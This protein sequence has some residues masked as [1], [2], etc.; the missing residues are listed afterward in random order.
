MPMDLKIKFISKLEY[1]LEIVKN[2]IKNKDI[3]SWHSDVRKNT[4][5][6]RYVTF[7]NE[8]NAISIESNP[9]MSML[10]LC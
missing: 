1:N 2:R 9:E 5:L 7:K 10:C 8:F 6:R 3:E 4:K